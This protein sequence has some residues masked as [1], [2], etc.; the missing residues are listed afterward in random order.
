MHHPL[1]IAGTRELQYILRASGERCLVTHRTE[2]SVHYG[3][4][5]FHECGSPPQPPFQIVVG[6]PGD[7]YR[8]QTEEELLAFAR[9]HFGRLMAPTTT[10]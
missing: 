6:V 2:D 5:D 3:G 4:D 7:V 1:S 8:F 9:A 10:E